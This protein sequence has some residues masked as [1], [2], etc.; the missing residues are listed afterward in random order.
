VWSVVT[1]FA[2]RMYYWL[3]FELSGRQRLVLSSKLA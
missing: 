2:H 3:S 1:E